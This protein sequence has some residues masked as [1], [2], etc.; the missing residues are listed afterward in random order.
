MP[1]DTPAHREQDRIIETS[2]RDAE[3]KEDR[4]GREAF[5][6]ALREGFAA[7]AQQRADRQ[8]ARGIP[9][10]APATPVEAAQREATEARRLAD[11]KRRAAGK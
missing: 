7:K 4:P 2:R 8:V 5:G 11:E 3:R 10:K 9:L 6:V 1:I